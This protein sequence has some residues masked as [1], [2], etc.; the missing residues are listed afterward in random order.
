MLVLSRKANQTV[1]FP[2]LGISVEIVN[3]AGKTVSIGV[4]APH[5]IRVLRGEL[6]P[7]ESVLSSADSDHKRQHELRNRLNKANL[8]LKLLQ[9]Q[10]QRGQTESA[11]ESLAIALRTL[12]ELE[13]AVSGGK[14]ANL[15]PTSIV[16]RLQN[17]QPRKRALLVED[18]ANERELLASYLRVCGYDVDAVEDGI[19]ALEYLSTNKPDAVVMDMEMPRL[20][21]SETVQAIRN[22]ARFDDLKLFVVSGMEQKKMR[23][24][25]GKRGVQHWFQKPLQPEDLVNKLA[26]SLN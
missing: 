25:V 4:R 18:D 6:V 26:S 16:P 22:D 8:A 24:P 21:G 10:L 15:E 3:I 17:S 9:K 5:D 1:V 12:E 2:S 14:R 20:N 23:M 13:M 11:E 19:A 7:P